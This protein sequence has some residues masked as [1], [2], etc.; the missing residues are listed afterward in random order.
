MSIF[1]QK[2]WF[3]LIIVIIVLGMAGAF[4]YSTFEKKNGPVYKVIK[5]APDFQLE[6]LEGKKVSLGDTGGKARLMYFF[7]STC[8][9]VCL[10]TTFML[11]KVQDELKKEGYFGDKTALLSVTFDPVR[12]TP[13]VLK[14]FADTYHADQNGW[15][16]LR[17]D[18]AQIQKIA[19]QFG[20]M[21][22]KDAKGNFSHSNAILLIDK[23]GNIRN[24]YDASDV[25][26]KIAD[27]VKD[28]IR[29]TKE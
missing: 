8:P 16:F 25:D 10:P 27:M 22:I 6:N 14:K 23:Q 12:D 24:Y 21:V 3:K 2:H 28:L 4:S 1:I 7:Y 11:S 26:L 18:E 19:E 29:I 17:G 15:S 5:K 9:D 13:P 20:V